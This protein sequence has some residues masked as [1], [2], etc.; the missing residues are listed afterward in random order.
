MYHSNDADLPVAGEY[1]N[2]Q[3]YNTNTRANAW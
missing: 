2:K 1:N 3:Q